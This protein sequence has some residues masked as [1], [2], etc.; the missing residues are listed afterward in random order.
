MTDR[1][2]AT[3]EIETPLSLMR[4]AQVAAGE[5]ST[6]TFVRLEAETDELRLRAGAR[7][8]DIVTVGVKDRPSL[9]C[10]LDGKRYERGLVTVSWP[11]ANTGPSLPNLLATIAGN[12]FELAEM[13]AIRLVALDVPESFAAGNPG[14]AVGIEGTRRLVDVPEGPII[15][16]I[17]KPSIGLSASE[18]ASLAGTLANAGLDFIKDDELQSNGPGCPL[19]ERA[20]A[21]MRV[22]NDH[23]EGA[24][25]KVMYAFNI[26]DEMD[27]MA[28]H[29]EKLEKLGAT[30]LMVS[31]NWIGVTGLRFL[32][33]RTALPIHGHRNGWGLF[34]RSPDIGIS[35]PVMQKIWRMAGAD[36]IHVNGLANKF[37]EDDISV[38]Q[39]ARSVQAPL[40]GTELCGLPVFSSGQ[41]VWQVG[42]TANQLGNQDFLIC[43]GGGIMS[44]PGGVAA[45]VAAFRQAAEAARSG[46]SLEEYAET[47]EEL[48]AALRHFPKPVL[49]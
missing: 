17:V 28:R 16:T 37:T 14:P 8:E 4:A 1:F 20:E 48:K 32:R 2:L 42:P 11:M 26:T 30:C 23:A 47:G 49:G 12:L 31:M 13:S 44:H 39:A 34:S 36:H 25:R 3:Y 43:A 10:R 7:I 46:S 6:G 22:L 15:G 5:Q 35:F 21:V 29:A 9:P 41:T 40:P 24:G 38:M 45:G 33:D 19:M 27:A 18:T